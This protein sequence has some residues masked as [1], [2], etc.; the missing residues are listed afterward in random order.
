MGSYL[1]EKSQDRMTGEKPQLLEGR[2]RG[3]V[4][5]MGWVI[6]WTVGLEQKQRAV[7]RVVVPELRTIRHTDHWS[8]SSY[9]SVQ[10]NMPDCLQVAVYSPSYLTDERAA[11]QL[12]VKFLRNKR[13]TKPL[14]LS[15]VCY[16]SFVISEYISEY[17]AKW[18]FWIT[19]SMV[20]RCR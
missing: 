7:W 1:K 9:S 11:L 8:L 6:P 15:L 2:G 17:K 3:Y 18:D 20:Q 5:N 10:S 13:A 14:L 4:G 12:L 16:S 19:G